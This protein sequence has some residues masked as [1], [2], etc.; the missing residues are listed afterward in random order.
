MSLVLF[1]ALQA[2]VMAKT[3]DE[4]WCR[5]LQRVAVATAQGKRMGIPREDMMR[6]AVATIHDAKN[7]GASM[8]VIDM[9]YRG[10]ADDRIS[11]VGLGAL[12]YASC[13]SDEGNL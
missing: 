7:L 8:I 13:M 5:S 1:V 6:A 3:Q 4:T 10:N 12:V 9:A 11:P 2:G